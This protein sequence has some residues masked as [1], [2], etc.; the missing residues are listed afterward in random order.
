LIGQRIAYTAV[1]SK[2]LSS[3]QFGALPRC[4]ATDLTAALLHD[5]EEALEGGSH[6]HTGH[7]GGQGRLRRRPTQT[8][9]PPSPRAGLACLPGG[10]D[11][12]FHAGP[13]S[14]GQTK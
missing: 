9:D 8:P 7:G 11:R 1:T 13:I 6:L 3:Q 10:L 5:V 12:I 2:V 4:S 14:C